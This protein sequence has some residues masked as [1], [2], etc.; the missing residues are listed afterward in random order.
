MCDPTKTPDGY[1]VTALRAKLKTWFSREGVT[2]GDCIQWKTADCQG[3]A[4]LLIPK[5][6]NLLATTINQGL[7]GSDLIAEVATKLSTA[8]FDGRSK[9]GVYE[10]NGRFAGA[11]SKFT[12]FHY[13]LLVH[14]DRDIKGRSFC[15]V[16]DPDVS[17]TEKSRTAWANGTGTVLPD[18]S[19]ADQTLVDTMILGSGNDLGPLVRYYYAT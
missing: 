5:K 6:C 9:I 18:A 4:Q 16:F 10:T 19:K 1:D 11:T 2:L 13:V 3:R 14:A 12:G 8:A 7:S 15:V 17:A